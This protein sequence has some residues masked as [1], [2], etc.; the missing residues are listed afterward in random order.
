MLCLLNT[1]IPEWVD[2]AAAHIDLLLIDHAHC[3]KK[4]AYNALTMI[5]NYPDYE[6]IVKEMIIVLKEEWD[7]FERVYERIREKGLNLVKDSGNEYAKQL[8]KHA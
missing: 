5:Q 1:T 7:H 3:E 8:S 4:A 6:D 2:I